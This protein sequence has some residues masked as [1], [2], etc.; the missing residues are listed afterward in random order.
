MNAVLSNITLPASVPGFAREEVSILASSTL[1][2][3]R[4][5]G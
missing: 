5:A 1:F 3:F 2:R 4:R